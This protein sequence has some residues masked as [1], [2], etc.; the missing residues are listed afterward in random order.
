MQIALLDVCVEG[1][2]SEGDIV[3]AGRQ[4]GCDTGSDLIE[5]NWRDTVVDSGLVILPGVANQS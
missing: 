5:I 2:V 1:V 4:I 3:Q